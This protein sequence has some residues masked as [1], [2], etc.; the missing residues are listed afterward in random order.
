MFSIRYAV[1]IIAFAANSL[2]LNTAR[3]LGGRMICSAVYGRQ[4]W[5][6]NPGYT[7]IAARELFLESSPYSS[8]VLN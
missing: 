2:A 8:L 3:D 6:A 4:C 7:A 1:M 5:T